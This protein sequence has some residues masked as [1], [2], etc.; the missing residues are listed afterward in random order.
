MAV[1]IVLVGTVGLLHDSWPR[2]S[3][4]FWI[5]LHALI[6]LS[7]WILIVGRLWWRLRHPPPAPTPDIGVLTHRLAYAVHLLAALWHQLVRRDRLLQRMWPRGK[8]R[9]RA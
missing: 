3:Q 9:T 8:P 6:G 5:N 2:Q 1:L 4:G 7:V